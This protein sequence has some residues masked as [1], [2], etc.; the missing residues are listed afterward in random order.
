MGSSS[1][2]GLETWAPCIGS[3]SLSHW[4]TK[5][6]PEAKILNIV[7]TAFLPCHF[8]ILRSSKKQQS[9]G[10]KPIALHSLCDS[11]VS[12][13]TT[14]HLVPWL[15]DI[16]NWFIKYTSPARN[17]SWLPL[18]IFYKVQPRYYLFW[19][20]F[21]ALPHQLRIK[22]HSSLKAPLALSSLGTTPH[23]LAYCWTLYQTVSIQLRA[24]QTPSCQCT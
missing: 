10:F 12:F 3:R 23:I 4:T 1:W 8:L 24:L 14:Y 21:P 9:T 6:I 15:L 19:E 2:L 20:V 16:I 13:C 7:L 18:F 5:E 22:S 11:K 17:I